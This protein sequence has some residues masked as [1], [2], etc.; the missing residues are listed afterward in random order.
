MSV[1]KYI[2]IR[3]DMPSKKKGKVF[4][5]VHLLVGYNQQTIADY[6]EMAKELRKT[7]PDAK[8]SELMCSHVTK[9]R[10]CEGFTLLAYNA[11]IDDKEYE[12]WGRRETPPDYFW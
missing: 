1:H 7:F 8:D 2:Y 12:G 5:N 4:A 6:Q 11:E 10:Y 9:S 3:R